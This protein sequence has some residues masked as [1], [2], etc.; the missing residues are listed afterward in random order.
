MQGTVLQLEVAEGDTVEAGQVVAVVEAMKMENEVQALHA[1]T[2]AAV[3]V[4]TGQGVQAG[5]TLIE[6]EGA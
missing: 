5:Q 1:G 6:L 2:V 3:H 4:Q